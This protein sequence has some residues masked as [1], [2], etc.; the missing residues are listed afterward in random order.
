LG[1]NFDG[2]SAELV[3]HILGWM[4]YAVSPEASP[5]EV[6]SILRC[7]DEPE[8]VQREAGGLSGVPPPA[9]LWADV[10]W[11]RA[12]GGEPDAGWPA[13]TGADA[14]EAVA[15]LRDVQRHA[16]A[17]GSAPQGRE[18]GEQRPGERDDAVRAL[19]C[20]M[21][22]AERQ[23]R[24]AE[25]RVSRWRR[26]ALQALGNAVVPQVAEIVARRVREIL[27]AGHA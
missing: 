25:R 17:D 20:A 24:K 1:R 9:V 12:S 8:A 15:V 21:A 22:L 7:L 2:F 26:S 18:P 3:G 5:S 13:V 4:T 10:L 16:S 27:E 19:S 14:D 11:T 6:M 23:A